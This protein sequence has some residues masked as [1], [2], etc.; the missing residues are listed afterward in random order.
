M[1]VHHRKLALV[2]SLHQKLSNFE[3]NRN[4]SAKLT[5][6]NCDDIIIADNASTEVHYCTCQHTES[7]YTP[8]Q[9]H[10]S[11]RFIGSNSCTLRAWLVKLI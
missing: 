1:I 3:P 9:F 2:G 11:V 10:A 6:R 4:E 8:P 7:L 5:G